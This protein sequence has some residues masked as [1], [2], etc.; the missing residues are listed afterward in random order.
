M[1]LPKKLSKLFQPELLSSVVTLLLVPRIRVRFREEV[2]QEHCYLIMKASRS[3][4]SPHGHHPQLQTT[5]T[6]FKLILLALSWSGHRPAVPSGDTAVEAGVGAGAAPDSI[7]SYSNPLSAPQEP[8]NCLTLAGAAQES[9][10]PT[11]TARSRKPRR[12]DFAICTL[13]RKQKA[14]EILIP[15]TPWTWRGPFWSHSS[16][17]ISFALPC[18]ANT[19]A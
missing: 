12:E 1:N 2:R 4:R 7:Q 11:S 15:T 9:A 18:W 3:K 13:G 17:D 16:A 19:E 14:T 6:F 8:Q 10:V 5:V